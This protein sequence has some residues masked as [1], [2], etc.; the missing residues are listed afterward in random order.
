MEYFMEY[1]TDN[2]GRR[3]PVDIVKPVDKLRDQTVRSI[4]ERTFAARDALGAFKAEVWA[5]IQAFLSLSAEEHGVAYGGKKGN[6]TLASYDGRYKLI[7]AVNDTVQFNEK[8]QVAKTLIDNCI[9]RWADG[10]R[11]EIKLLV[12]DAFYVDKQGNI[13]T[14]RIL[15]LRRLA[16]ADPE[17]RKAMQAISD[18]VQVASSKTYM[19]F[20]E[21][22]QDGAYKQIPLD[23]AAL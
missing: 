17:W 21:R 8:L 13:N 12:E 20:Y 14:N 16:I 5:D 7:I 19:R 1:M 15:G 10:S 11:S 4:M 9:R 18:S 6:I 23:V 22:Q 2:Q 3:V